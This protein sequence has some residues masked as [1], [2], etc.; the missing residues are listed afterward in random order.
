MK[1]KVIID[2]HREEEIVIYAHSRTDV[3]ERIEQ[4]V[5]TEW[6]GYADGEVRPL[7]AGDIDCFIV[8]DNKVFA[9]N[10]QGKWQIRER[11]YRI[12]ERLGDTFVRIN[13]S[14]LANIRAIDRFEVSIGAS[15]SVIFVG[16]YRDYVSRRQMKAVKERL[17]IK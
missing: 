17:G 14:C 10:R 15:L 12:E 7:Q 8:E 16:G 5:A 11:L 3:V 13:Q 2:P 6:L 1:C 4:M 9:V